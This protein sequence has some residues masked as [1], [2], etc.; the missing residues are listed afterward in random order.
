MNSVIIVITL[1]GFFPLEKLCFLNL[2]RVLKVREFRIHEDLLKQSMSD[3][4]N[5]VS[6]LLHQIKTDQVN[7]FIKRQLE[8]DPFCRFSSL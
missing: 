1:K 4:I 5:P 8:D 3:L 6:A 7:I 2:M